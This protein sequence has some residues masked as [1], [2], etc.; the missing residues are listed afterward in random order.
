MAPRKQTPK[1]SGK[2]PK[3]TVSATPPLLEGAVRKRVLHVGCG[4]ANPQKLH[5]SFRGADWEEVRMD[6]DPAVKPDIVSDMTDM[7]VV[8]DASVEAVWSSHNVEHLFAHQVPVALAEFYRVIKFGG[9]ALITLPD[10]QAVAEHIARGNLEQPLYQSP[11]GPISALDITYGFGAA[12]ARGNVFMAHKTAFTAQTLGNKLHQAGF[13]NVQVKR[14]LFDLW[15][16]AYK[17]PE[18][19][20]NANSKIVIHDPKRTNGLPDELDVPP[21]RWNPLNLY[22]GHKEFK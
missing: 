19:H 9:F 22:G 10:I 8:A 3:N 16:V 12:I 13:V 18:N 2:A 11:G 21:V 7:S 4:V 1:R 20:P 14:E 6:I 15:A 5:A 17:L